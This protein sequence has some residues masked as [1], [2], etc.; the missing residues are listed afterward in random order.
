MPLAS[1]VTLGPGRCGGRSCR[2]GQPGGRPVR[3]PSPRAPCAQ[4]G[5]RARAPANTFPAAAA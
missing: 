3:A 1:G 2:A 5:S 4:S